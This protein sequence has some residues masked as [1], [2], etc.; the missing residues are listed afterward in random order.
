MWT[1]LTHPSLHSLETGGAKGGL[2]VQGAPHCLV[3]PQGCWRLGPRGED[4]GAARGVAGQGAWSMGV[5]TC[6]DGGPLPRRAAAAPVWT[7]PGTQAEWPQ[8][9]SGVLAGRL[10]LLSSLPWAGPQR[11][12]SWLAM[13][14]A[15]LF[16]SGLCLRNP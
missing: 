11:D 4:P 5:V 10:S 9:R 1:Q 14:P 8:G 15:G 3:G 13:E 7:S 6:L 12:R 16:T 2:G